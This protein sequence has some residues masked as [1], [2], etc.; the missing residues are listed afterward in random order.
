[1]A[2]ANRTETSEAAPG[3][4]HRWQKGESG[5]PSGRP[6]TDKGLITALETIVDKMALARALV[7]L[8]KSKNPSVRLQAIKYIYDRIEG[9]P[10]Q[11]HEFDPATARAEAERLA[12]EL[13][14]PNVDGVMSEVDDIIR[15]TS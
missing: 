11:R 5:N 14:L 7:R 3:R 8:T 10:T 1:M 12:V 9:S 13:G 15:N 6:K 4:P 2:V